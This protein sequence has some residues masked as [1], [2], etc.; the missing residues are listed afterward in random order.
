MPIKK[1][2]NILHPSITLSTLKKDFVVNFHCQAD[3]TPIID[4]L[5]S[6]KYIF[7]ACNIIAYPIHCI[8]NESR[9]GISSK[10]K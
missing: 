7:Y 3:Q 1:F 10:I 9:Y 5:K 4:E 8:H 6:I 2:F